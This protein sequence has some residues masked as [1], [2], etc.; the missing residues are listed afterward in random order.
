MLPI[1]RKKNILDLINKKNFISTQEL[2]DNL[3][4]SQ[5]TIRRDLVEME[6]EN[7]IIRSHGGA[8]LPQESTSEPTY[9]YRDNQNQTEKRRIA[10]MA[11]TFIEDGFS[12]FLDSSTT[13]KYVVPYL[14]QFKNLTIV[15][16]GIQTAL[17]LSKNKHL[18]TILIGGSLFPGSSSIVGAKANEALSTYK[19]DLSIISCRG[20]DGDGVYEANEPQAMIKQKMIKNSRAKL[21][22]C[23]SNKLNKSFFYKLTDLDTFNYIITDKI[24]NNYIQQTFK[25]NGVM[26]IEA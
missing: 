10:D 14:N 8:M 23:D 16:N 4:V 7:L 15:T 12:L 9:I 18:N 5:A 26:L 17:D 13:V 11:S 1:E 6:S 21:L 20:L 3:F 19:V 2:C 22:L 25:D 24:P